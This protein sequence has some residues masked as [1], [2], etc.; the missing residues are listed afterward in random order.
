MRRETNKKIKKKNKRSHL[1][2]SGLCHF[3]YSRIPPVENGPFRRV[4]FPLE[5]SGP[6]CRQS[7]RF[8]SFCA[9]PRG[10]WCEGVLLYGTQKSVG[11]SVLRAF[12]AS[13]ACFTRDKP[14][15]ERV[16]GVGLSRKPP[17]LRSRRCTQPRAVK[18]TAGVA[19][20]S[21]MA[22]IT[23]ATTAVV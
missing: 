14:S 18:A 3:L 6:F 23:R 1:L 22:S 8:Y 7:S 16:G 5:S 11:S 2:F 9:R 19:V 21:E 15:S 4:F 17:N 12:F 20:V 13:N 10:G